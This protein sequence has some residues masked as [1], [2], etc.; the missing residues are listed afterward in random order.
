MYDHIIIGAGSAGCVLANRLT[1]DGQR[2]VLLL[3]AG[4][5]GRDEPYI[6]IPRAWRRL[7]RTAVD[8]VY[9]TA[10]QPAINGRQQY[11]PRGKTLGGS[12]ATN[13]MIYIRGQREDY[14]EWAKLGCAGWDYESL[15]P[16]FKQM[17]HQERGADAFHGTGG[18]LNV[19]D[20]SSPNPLAKAFVQAGQELGYPA[21]PDFNGASQ[22]GFGLLQ[23][24]QKEGRRH[25][26]ADAFLHPIAHRPNLTIATGAQA[27]RILFE[28]HTAVGVEFA[29]DGRLHTARARGEI[30]LCGGAINT[31]Q[32]LLLS[33]VGPAT[34]LAKWGIP[35]VVELAGVGQNLQ[36]HP[37]VYVPFAIP[38]PSSIAEWETAANLATWQAHGTGVASSNISEATAF[39][40]TAAHVGR[41]DLQYHFCPMVVTNTPAT[42]GFSLGA[43]LLRPASR[44]FVSLASPDPLAAPLIQPNYLAEEAD[45]AVLVAGVLLAR[46]L[47]GT[48][49]F[50]PHQPT[51]LEPG[52][53]VSQDDEEAIREFIRQRVGTMYHPVGTCQMGGEADEAAVVTPDLRVRGLANLRIADAS[54]MPRIVSGNTNAP[55]MVI[56]EKAFQLVS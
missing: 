11:W 13:A 51:E 32:L 24:T 54:I 56:A 29:Q 22:E 47:A 26:A 18:E 27:T 36:D 35:Q 30:W 31:P 49:A 19:A 3:E 1:A 6:P 39:V 17:A 34:E 50:A 7:F 8:W 37:V 2:T 15:L 46:R 25:S 10:A 20:L 43:T 21:N 53:A 55:V 33:G 45:M 23:V 42:H 44:G 16:L 41:P 9:K 40:R 14:D 48:A 5:D 12:S 38:A 4:G 52:T 28:G